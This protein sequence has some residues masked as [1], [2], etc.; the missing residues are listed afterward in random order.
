MKNEKY[1]SPAMETV[2]IETE[3]PILYVSGEDSN[4]YVS[5]EDS[6]VIESEE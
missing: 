2:E 5:G 6:N 3:G 1:L 4:L